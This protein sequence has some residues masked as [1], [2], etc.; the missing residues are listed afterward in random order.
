MGL[1]DSIKNAIIASTVIV[2]LVTI[3]AM[4]IM[5]I[6]KRR[7]GNVTKRYLIVRR[8]ITISVI[9]LAIVLSIT[10]ISDY[11]IVIN[12]NEAP[13]VY[14]GH[15]QEKKVYTSQGIADSQKSVMV[16][17][18]FINQFDRRLVKMYRGNVRAMRMR[19]TNLKVD[20]I[21]LPFVDG[22]TR[23]SEPKCSTIIMTLLYDGKTKEV[24]S[25]IDYMD[26]VTASAVSMLDKGFKYTKGKDRIEIRWV[27]EES[28]KPLSTIVYDYDGSK[29]A[30]AN[31]EYHEL[32]FE[33]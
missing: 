8:I 15:A 25:M 1:S 24:M 23:T 19:E 31:E 9:L 14:S 10:V 12:K 29:M 32:L 27:V 21:D 11:R 28:G 2:L 26:D 13:Q 30:L 16:G 4:I 20:D 18:I 33:E 22:C 17:T 5:N 3:I 6:Y 7:Y